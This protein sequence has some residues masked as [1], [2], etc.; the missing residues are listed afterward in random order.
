MQNC[1][2]MPRNGIGPDSSRGNLA[3]LVYRK[4]GGGFFR[5]LSMGHRIID[6]WRPSMIHTKDIEEKLNTMR[7]CV[8]IMLEDHDKS[9]P[10]PEW[11]KG[12]SV[13]VDVINKW[14]QENSQ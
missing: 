6:R 14:V 10:M 12:Y 11:Y 4:V 1:A 8:K 7:E 3:A 9:L 5:A 13:A 2:E